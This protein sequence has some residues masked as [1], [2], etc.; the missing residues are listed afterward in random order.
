ML[1]AVVHINWVAVF[2]ATAVSFI[3]GGLWFTVIFGKK[4]SE[5]LERPYDPKQKPT[6]IFIVGPLMC[7]FVSTIATAILI[8]WCNITTY[9]E[10]LVFSLIVGL[11]LQV[12]VMTN[13]AINPN[14]PR[15]FA[16]SLVCG[17]YFLLICMFTSLTLV[18]YG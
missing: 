18:W 17:P 15:P 1:D 7:G 2:V 14:M 3:F 6:K 5:A 4:Y 9:E 12:A 16:Y 11:G 10:T 8:R 13:T